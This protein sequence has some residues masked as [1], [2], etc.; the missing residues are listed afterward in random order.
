[1]KPSVF[2]SYPQPFNPKQIQ[3]INEISE[4]L[5]RR[6]FGPRTLGVTDYDMDAPLKAIRRLMLES[7][8]LITVAFRRTQIKSGTTKPGTPDEKKLNNAWLTSP[9]SHIEPAM[10]F[11]IGLP[12][13]IIREKGVISDGVLEKGVI[14]TYMPEF[15]L[16]KSTTNYLASQEWEQI[17]QKWEGYVRKVIEQKGNP[18]CLY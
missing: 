2:L 15:D 7:N 6:G 17:I 16:E 4:Y 14:G 1:M 18:P 12:V 10:A 5:E 9:Y 13:L 3:F 11:Q 8:G